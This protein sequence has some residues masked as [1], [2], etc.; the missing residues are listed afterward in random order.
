[1]NKQFIVF[2]LCLLGLISICQAVALKSSN[3]VRVE[4]NIALTESGCNCNGTQ[5]DCCDVVPPPVATTLCLDSIWNAKE[6][7]ITV[8]VI[9][10][11]AAIDTIT[12]T[13]LTFSQII[14][15]HFGKN[16]TLLNVLAFLEEVY[17]SLLPISP[18]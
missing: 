6:E 12:F 1:M 11:G 15:K 2:S 17:A 5:C 10:G 3:V 9:F 8:K 16:K 13:G 18:L 4:R 14:L 7:S